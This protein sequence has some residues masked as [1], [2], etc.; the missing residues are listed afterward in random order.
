MAL[1][2]RAVR[3]REAKEEARR[4]GYEPPADLQLQV[5]MEHDHMLHSDDDDAGGLGAAPD[6]GRA[7]RI[8]KEI[9][10]VLQNFNARRQP[11]RSRKE[12][13]AAVRVPFPPAVGFRRPA[14]HT[15]IPPA[16]ASEAREGILHRVAPGRVL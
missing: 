14:L 10:F 16:P 6:L 12:Y 1:L 9:Q 3:E 4:M 8:V 11:G 15:S 2:C 7:E 13:V 5:G